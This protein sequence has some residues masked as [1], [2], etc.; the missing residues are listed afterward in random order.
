MGCSKIEGELKERKENSMKRHRPHLKES[1]HHKPGYPGSGAG[2]AKSK[3]EPTKTILTSRI[4]ISANQ[5]VID[6]S[7]HRT[8]KMMTV[9]L[10][11]LHNV[12]I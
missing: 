3:A 7:I 2:A 9:K 12:T 5:E 1:G 4:S 8:R 6:I 11:T 10:V